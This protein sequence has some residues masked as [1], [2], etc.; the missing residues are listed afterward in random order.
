MSETHVLVHPDP[1]Q[2]AEAVAARLLAR[3]AELQ[4]QRGRASLILAGGGVVIDSLAA[5][6]E[7]SARDAVDWGAI[8]V[9]WSD[10]RFLP[11]GHPERNALQ[12]QRALLDTLSLDP[13]RVHPMPAAGADLSGPELSAAAEDAAAA[14]AAEL[15]A[16]APPSSELPQFDVLLLGMGGEGHTASIFPESPAVYD[17]RVVTAVHGCPKPPPTRITF[18]LPTIRTAEEVWILTAGEGKAP[19]V[20]LALQGAGETQIPVAGARGQRRTMWF[21]DRAAATEVPNELRTPW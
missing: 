8:D 18:T 11:A 1:P 13:G 17:T 10:E 5:V 16:S 20:G 6:R 19:A 3:L 2:L 4:S 14:Y 12:A 9:W 21:L 7:S 15:A